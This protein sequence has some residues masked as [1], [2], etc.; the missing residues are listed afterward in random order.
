[1][2]IDTSKNTQNPLKQLNIPKMESR[3]SM[4][5]ANVHRENRIETKRQDETSRETKTK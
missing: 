2:Q 4:P 3:V 5:Y 1:M